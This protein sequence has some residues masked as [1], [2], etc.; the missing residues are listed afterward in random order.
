MERLNRRYVVVKTWFARQIN[1]T[2]LKIIFYIFYR[3]KFFD[4]NNNIMKFYTY[5]E[6]LKYNVG[7]LNKLSRYGRKFIN[8]K[9]LDNQKIQ[10]LSGGLRHLLKTGFLRHL[11]QITLFP[12]HF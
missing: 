1:R 7:T 2:K 6:I 9:S 5:E 3:V 8:Q 4:I 10:K 12:K 11:L